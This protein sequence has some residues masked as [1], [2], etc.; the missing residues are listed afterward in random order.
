MTILTQKMP[1]N[2][3]VR[4]SG[5]EAAPCA[6]LIFSPSGDVLCANSAAEALLGGAMSD[7]RARAM[8]LT[9]SGSP[10]AVFVE[11]AVRRGGGWRQ[12]DLELVMAGRPPLMV[13]AAASV[14][15]DGSVVVTLHPLA[16]GDED[17]PAEALQTA[18]NLGRTLAHE[19]K[20]PLAG[21]R[22][23][24]QLLKAGASLE[25]TALAQLIMDET[26]RVRR[27]V[28]RLEAF[29]DSRRLSL[30]PLN[31]HRILDR[32]RAL[33]VNGVGEGLMFRAAYDPSLPPVLG[34]EDQL[35]QVFLNLVK[36][37]ADAARS[38]RDDRGEVVI[39]TAFR[40]QARH[41][42]GEGPATPLEVK[43]QDNGPGVAPDVRR[44]LFD[45]FVT[46]KPNG[47]GLGLTVAA[48]VVAA[49]EGLID[50]QSEPGRTVFR[51]LLP[52][53]DQSHIDPADA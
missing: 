53:S 18:A 9:A 38:R 33:V 4:C 13:D 52:V 28:E 39:S 10:L 46:G 45:P 11:R 48:Q 16:G 29:S 50:F 43:V 20:N 7:R 12:R 8:G 3:A 42:D 26:D 1:V 44:R 47:T 41:V 31:I 32:V 14:A 40:H 36:N 2:E 22:G 37:A 35:V 30:Q 21:I 24:A 23:A 19:I 17:A 25:D 15:P 6:L 49:H 27:L 5:F 51:V 34:D